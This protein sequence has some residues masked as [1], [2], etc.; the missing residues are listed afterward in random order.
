M[1]LLGRWLILAAIIFIVGYVY[2]TY[3]RRKA[4]LASDAP[5]APPPLASGLQSS[6]NLWTYN[7]TDGNCLHFSVSATSAKQQK[8]TMLLEGVELRLYHKCG[9]KYDLIKSANAQF[10]MIKKELSS[11]GDV[12][13]TLA[14]PE[15]ETP[16]GRLLNIHASGVHFDQLTSKATTDKPATFEFDQGSGSATGAEY[17]PN[18]RELHMMSAVSIDWRG[19]RPD[20][21]PMHIEAGEAFYREREA[22]IWLMPWSKLS[23]DTLHVEGGT[24]VIT[25]ENRELHRIDGVNA[26]GV[27]DEPGRKI[28][29]AADALGMDFGENAVI[30]GISGDK[31]ARLV[32]TSATAQM[33]VTSDRMDL[34]FKPDVVDG[35]T[36][37]GKSKESVFDA[38]STKGHSVAESVPVAKPGTQLADTRI[39]KSDVLRLKM[40]D[41]GREMESAETAGPGTLDLVP[42]RPGQPK[43]SLKGDQIWV[44]YG[45]ENKIQSFRSVNVSTE[46]ERPPKAGQPAGPPALTQSKDIL[47]TF[48]AKTGDLAQVE[49][50]TDFHYQEGDRQAKADVAVMDQQK[51]VMTLDRNARAWDSTGSTTADHMVL[52]QKSGDFT[53][54]G[55]VAS[56]RQPDPKAKPS[57]ML[58][59]DE[60]RQA[61]AQRMVST[62]KNKKVHYEG[63]AVAWQGANRVN[64]D[65]LDIDQDKHVMEADSNVVSQFTDKPKDG[66]AKKAGPP[67]TTVV[68]AGHMVYTD[69]TRVALYTGGVNL[70]RAA[71]LN[72]VSKQLQAFL[73][74]DGGS[75]SSLDKSIADGAVKIVSRQAATP[76][77]PARSKVGTSEHSE[78]Y[79]DEQKVILTGGAPKLVESPNGNTTTGEQLTWWANDDK[80]LVNGSAKVPPKSTIHTK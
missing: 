74:K 19:K 35:K 26:K 39:L 66:A 6:S 42:N 54:E 18:T 57:G 13:I 21:K 24:A 79:A 67:M 53:A 14:V 65:R 72:V 43:R 37:D 36:A 68:H 7:E 16:H 17:D 40:R 31:N 4:A 56:I 77:K 29:F 55:H 69:D 76:A 30:S 49:Q 45:A 62:N 22:K 52:D 10:D 8:D 47:A 32:S 1:R 61:Q 60:V 41:G 3:E 50:K 20:A 75:D 73:K 44:T 25:L 5:A 11:D 27:R 2:V 78:Y 80:L 59:N 38:A 15:E 63:H 46:T 23:R 9:A 33:T 34:A 64:A 28:E 12:T 58:S 48:D 71:E 51:D 70:T